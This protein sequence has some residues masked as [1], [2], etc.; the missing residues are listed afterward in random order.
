MIDD[1]EAQLAEEEERKKIAELDAADTTGA[2]RR[3]LGQPDFNLVLFWLLGRTGL[4]VN[5]FSS[6]EAAERYQLGRHS[7]A[8]ELLSKIDSIDSTAYPRMLLDRAQ[9]RELNRAAK[10]ARSRKSEGREEDDYA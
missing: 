9:Q 7:V 5:S 3:L 8:L 2:F 10:E 6:D 1:Y 4:Y